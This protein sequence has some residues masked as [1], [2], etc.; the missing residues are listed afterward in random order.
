MKPTRLA[1]ALL[2]ALTASGS[3][4][5][6]AGQQA[7]PEGAQ[8]PNILLI[9]ADD[10][11]HA[12]FSYLRV[13]DDVRTPRLDR[14][15]ASGVSFTNAYATSPIC[16]PS[17]VGLITGRYQQRWNNYFY[18]GGQGLPAESVT[19]AERLKDAGY[20]TG[21]FGKVHTGGPDRNPEAAGF[22]LNTGFDRFF[23]TT[24]GGRT[25]YLH[26][27]KA[28]ALE[29]GDAA[30]QMMVAP[31]WDDDEQIEFD[32]FTTEAFGQKARDFITDNQEQ[33]FFAMVAFNAVH[34]FAW[35]LPA[36]ELEARGLEPFPDWDPEIE[37]YK[38]WYKGVHRRDWPEG[39]AYYLAQLA[40]LDREVG[41]LLDHLAELGLDDNTLVIYTVDNGGCVPDWAD[42]GPLAGSKYHLLEGGTRTPLI[43]AMPG[44]VRVGVTSDSVV[45]G[46][47]FAPT[48]C[49]LVGLET[50]PDAFDGRSIVPIISRGVEDTQGRELHWDIGWQWS[51][52]RGDWKLMV[53]TNEN[54]ARGQ[55]QFEQVDVRLGTH[56]YNL[57]DDPGE[58]TN[59]A[60]A[61]PELVQQLRESHEAWRASIGQPIP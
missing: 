24:T 51:V 53:T 61:M 60:E 35:Q 52:R 49:E 41:R 19:L 4:A 59:L 29:Y 57:A 47:D 23:G 8:P 46:M 10:Q 31:M 27:S 15:A 30:R 1:H 50:E 22:P 12:D 32:G 39:R 13:N 14:L 6:S 11:G 26:H 28:A 42:N 18:G 16:N 36:A 44:T 37:P 48:V 20:A 56:L 38:E 45:S 25:H 34:N 9:L 55:A 17:R 7:Y 58:T 43:Y 5:Q 54:A 21:Y 2:L 33:P 40:C 3:P